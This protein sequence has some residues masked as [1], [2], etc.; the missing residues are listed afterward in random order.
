VQRISTAKKVGIQAAEGNTDKIYVGLDG[1][2]RTTDWPLNPGETL[3]VDDDTVIDVTQVYVIA[4]SGTQTVSWSLGA[5]SPGNW[6][7]ATGGGGP[8]GIVWKSFADGDAT[9][10]VS[11]GTYF[12]TANTGATT[13]TDFDG[14]TN[15]E[16]TILAGDGDTT[17]Q[18]NANITPEGALDFTMDANWTVVFIHNGTKWVEKSRSANS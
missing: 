17:I 18:N 7:A 1:N 10:D 4:A 14:A 2:A 11:G 3:A 5:I 15:A 12:K 8:T 6:A 13:I 16:I 9:P